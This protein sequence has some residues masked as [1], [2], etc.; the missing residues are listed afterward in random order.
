MGN[1]KADIGEIIIQSASVA[2]SPH[3]IIY[4]GSA[5]VGVVFVLLLATSVVVPILVYRW[6]ERKRVSE[7]R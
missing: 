5:V 3:K 7:M 4:I 6:R 2:H 1:F